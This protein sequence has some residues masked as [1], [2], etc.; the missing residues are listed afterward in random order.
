[1]GVCIVDTEMGLLRVC[2]SVRVR[3]CYCKSGSNGRQMYSALS[4]LVRLV[5]EMDTIIP[6]CNFLRVS[7]V[8]DT[9]HRMWVCGLHAMCVM[10][11][12]C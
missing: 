12:G 1:M 8:H 10:Q 9:L 3:N 6:T 2:G 4:T 11:I 5:G 7:Y